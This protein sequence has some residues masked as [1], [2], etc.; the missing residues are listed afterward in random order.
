MQFMLSRL[1]LA[2]SEPED[3][4][5][6]LFNK[7][8]QIEPPGELIARILSHIR[9]LP[10]PSARQAQPETPAIEEADA[11]VVRKEHCEPS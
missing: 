8:S 6:K 9:S 1:T 11:L 4:L 2:G 7:L 10:A 3:D 5:D